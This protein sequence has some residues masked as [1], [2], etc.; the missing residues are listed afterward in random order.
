MSQI[1]NIFNLPPRLFK[2]YSYDS[3]LNKKRLFGEIYL[4]CPF[5]FNDPCDCQR[6]I[7]NNINDR[8]REKGTLWIT[9]KM[10]ELNFNK[11]ESENIVDSLLIENKYVDIVHNRMLQKLGI[12]CLTV[13]QSDSLMWGYYARNEGICIEY[14]VTKLIRNIVVGFINKMDYQTTSFLF[15]DEKYYQLPEHRTSLKP[16]WYQFAQKL[17]RKQD[18]KRISNKFLEDQNDLKVLN[19]S[20]NILIK[21]IYAQSMIYKISPDGSPSPLFFDRKEKSSESKYFKKTNTWSHEKEFRVIVSLGGRLAI[22]VG[23]DCLKNIYLGCNMTNERIISIA[24]LM[25]KY[26]LNIGLYKMKRLKNCGLTPESIKW[27][28]YKD[29]LD[30]FEKDLQEKFP[31]KRF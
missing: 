26:K 17:I 3:I 8:V 4:A 13:T 1:Y 9:R 27:A 11:H 16:E 6:E 29:H 20:R 2:Y 12:L 25:S 30:L 18:I 28:Q 5:D 31:E 23:T 14:D 7:I 22:N 19:F 24:Y 10:S 15:K 21:R